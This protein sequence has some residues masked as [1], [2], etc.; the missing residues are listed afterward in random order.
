MKINAFKRKLLLCLMLSTSTLAF[1]AETA[2]QEAHKPV[3]T[4]LPAE[5]S[6]AHNKGQLQ[7]GLGLEC[8]GGKPAGISYYN[9]ANDLDVA[10]GSPVKIEITV[11]DEKPVKF[12]ATRIANKNVPEALTARSGDIDSTLYLIRK[13]ENSKKAVWV[14]VSNPDLHKT[15]RFN[16][17]ASDMPG[18]VKSFKS[19]CATE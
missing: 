9:A 6:M 7:Q 10:I 5:G 18:A 3:A 11:D 1:A 12:I 14:T 8:A 17:K 13:L 2:Q 4:L 15:T 19:F 16:L